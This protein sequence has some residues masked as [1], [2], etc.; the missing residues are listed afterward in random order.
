MADT[1]LGV[2][3]Y[4]ICI[5]FA[6]MLKSSVPKSSRENFLALF[7]IYINADKPTTMIIRIRVKKTM[8]AVIGNVPPYRSVCGMLL[9]TNPTY[10]GYK[11]S[12]I[13]NADDRHYGNHRHHLKV[14]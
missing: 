2:E 10:T 9:F 13:T 12:G 8:I 3:E 7:L 4:S 14:Q 6:A 1:D 5:S 11:P